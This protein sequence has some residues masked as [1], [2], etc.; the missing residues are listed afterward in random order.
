[1][2]ALYIRFA[3][4]WMFIPLK[5]Q[6]PSNDQMTMVKKASSYSTCKEKEVDIEKGKLETRRFNNE[7]L[8]NLKNEEEHK[9]HMSFEMGGKCMN[10]LMNHS[11]ILPKFSPRDNS[12]IKKVLE[13]PRMRKHK[14]TSFGPRNIALLSSLVSCLGTTILIYLTLKVKQIECM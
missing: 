9:K 13:P 2:Q 1:M 8:R 14:H 10:L 12:T 3:I 7:T 5:I 6:L 11:L 4:Q